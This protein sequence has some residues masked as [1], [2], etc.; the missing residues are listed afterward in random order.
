MVSNSHLGHVLS[1]SQQQR[2]GMTDLFA[3]Y[4]A[5]FSFFASLVLL[6]SR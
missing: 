1:I 5:A 4:L 2:A 6:E 3:D